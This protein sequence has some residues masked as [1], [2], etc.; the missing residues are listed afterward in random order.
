MDKNFRRQPKKITTTSP[1][2]YLLTNES[3]ATDHHR[4]HSFIEPD[5]DIDYKPQIPDQDENELQAELFE[6]YPKPLIDPKKNALVH[7]QISDNVSSKF[8]AFMASACRFFNETPGLT[9]KKPNFGKILGPRKA[10]FVPNKMAFDQNY[11]SYSD[12]RRTKKCT[13]ETQA[14]SEP[15]D[16]T[17]SRVIRNVF[18]QSLSN[19][20]VVSHLAKGVF[21]QPQNSADRGLLDCN[22]GNYVKAAYKKKGL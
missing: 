16:S 19:K 6:D 3:Q 18:D 12:M 14:S 17:Q 21:E 10:K 20:R 1:Q 22:D 9:A 2:K 5:F 4:S 7:R 13:L 11:L 8:G 15:K